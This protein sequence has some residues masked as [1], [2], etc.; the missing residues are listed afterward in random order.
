M[1]SDRRELELAPLQLPPAE[2]LPS[3]ERRRA[4]LV[5]KLT[6]AAG[7]EA[8]RH[9]GANPAQLATV[10]ASSGGDCDNCHHI[11]ETLASSDRAVSPTR[12]HNSVHNAPSGYWS[13][14]TDCMAPST[15]LGAYDATFA[16]GILET[17]T[18]ALAGGK[19]CML[20]AFDTAYPGPLNALRPIPFA[21]GVAMVL[22]PFK[23]TAA[24]ASLSLTLSQTTATVMADEQLEYLRKRV[25]AARSLPL[26]QHI[27]RGSNAKVVLEYLDAVNLDVTVQ[28]ES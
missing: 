27:A 21:F 9:A 3:A 16:A 7:F 15:S 18:Q 11:L 5:V 4:G 20:L 6:M 13:I 25:P 26:L 24:I 22:N 8:V 12:F 1:L 28:R 14:A 2:A 23:T 17:A 10:F 19:L